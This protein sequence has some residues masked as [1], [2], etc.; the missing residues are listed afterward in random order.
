MEEEKQEQSNNKTSPA[1][2]TLFGLIF[3]VVLVI[4]VLLLPKTEIKKES[5]IL[6][7]EISQESVSSD[8]E[9]VEDMTELEIEDLKVG[10][11]AEAK[12]GDVVSVHYVGTLTD[13]TKFDS[14]RDRGEPFSFELGAGEVIKGWDEGVVGMRI[15]GKRMLTIP[16]ELGYGELGAPPIIGPN[17]TL[18][19]EIELLEV[20]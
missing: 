17:A 13:G 5:K 16:S 15:G 3:I 14:S 4:I 7:T 2:A 18:I 10:E 12:P 11:G 19:F 9:V 8:E 6:Q 1:K 20:K